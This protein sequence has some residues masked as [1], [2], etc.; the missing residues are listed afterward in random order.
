MEPIE[1]LQSLL[2]LTDRL[3]DL[4]EAE[5]AALIERRF[6]DVEASLED[7][8]TL[9]RLYENNMQAANEAGI[10]WAATDPD[11]RERLRL[12]AERLTKAV[13]ENTMR[14]EVGM[15]A[16][17]YVIDMIADA[18]RENVPHSGT[19]ARNGK[20]GNEGAKAAINSVAVALDETL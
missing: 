7:K 18:V 19:Y 6:A 12:A 16:N 8:A 15:K 13:D 14:L 5:N 11:V 3:A 20:T 9:A 17:K 10:D 1:R 2:D 4:T